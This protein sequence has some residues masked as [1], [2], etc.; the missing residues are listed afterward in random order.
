MAATRAA[1]QV[2]PLP[3]AEAD[4]DG[5][6]W[7][8]PADELD[9]IQ[10]IALRAGE[11]PA[12]MLAGS[13]LQAPGD[14]TEPMREL[15][16]RLRAPGVPK[17]DPAVATH[18]GHHRSL[19][20]TAALVAALV[21]TAALGGYTHWSARARGPQ[22]KGPSDR[23]PDGGLAAASA[24]PKAAIDSDRSPVAAPVATPFDVAAAAAEQARLAALRRRPDAPSLSPYLRATLYQEEAVVLFETGRTADAVT[25]MWLAVDMFSG[26][27]TAPRP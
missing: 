8:P 6:V 22:A 20:R 7:P 2:D 25:L 10:V 1:L 23:P 27:G 12:S 15:E 21:S 24:A 17:T 16:C 19:V 5:L 11:L 14:A 26:I 18:P 3:R 9:T 13:G 4:D